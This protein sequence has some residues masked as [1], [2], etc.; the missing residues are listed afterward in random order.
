MF[1]QNQQQPAEQNPQQQPDQ[2][3]PPPPAAPIP[4]APGT[5]DVTSIRLPQNFGARIG[6]RKPLLTLPVRKPDRL[7]FSR[8]NPDPAYRVDTAIIE[9]DDALGKKEQYIVLPSL[10][11]E[12]PAS[13]TKV[14]TIRTAVTRQETPYLWWLKLYDS[15]GRVD[16]WTRTGLIAMEAAEDS[17]VRVTANSR[18]GAYDLEIATG[19]LPGPR[20]PEYSFDEI[21][22]AGFK[23]RYISSMD[24][25]VIR[26]LL[27]KM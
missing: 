26:T 2:Q 4:P 8:V 5:F 7:W 10:V 15:E 14:V 18:I 21:L 27:G 11:T 17:W 20:W 13:L 6:V 22:R 23:G 19:D 9:I 24:D 12:L 25:D 3:T 1:Q 16:E